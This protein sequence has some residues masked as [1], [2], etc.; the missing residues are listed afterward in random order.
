MPPNEHG[1]E[2]GYWTRNQVAA[3]LRRFASDA[4]VVRFIADMLEE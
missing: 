2:A 1:L 4:T 3:A